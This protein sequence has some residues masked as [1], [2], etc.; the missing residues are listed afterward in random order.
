MATNSTDNSNTQTPAV[1]EEMPMQGGGRQ[2]GGRGGM[3]MPRGDAMPNGEAPPAMPEGEMPTGEMTPPQDNGNAEIENGQQ[4]QPS[5]SENKQD[6]TTDTTNENSNRMQRGGMG[7]GM[8][9][10]NGGMP[11]NTQN[12]ENAETV[13][14][15]GI[16]DFIKTYSTPITSVILL[17]LAFVFVIFYK[18]KTY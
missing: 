6:T 18:R 5:N 13:S 15:G 16:L 7:G 12:T 8:G 14:Q 9:G 1:S 10:M 11:G 17:A 2:G 4:T 3:G